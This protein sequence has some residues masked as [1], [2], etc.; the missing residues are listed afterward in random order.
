MGRK[1]LRNPGNNL[2]RCQMFDVVQW[3]TWGWYVERIRSVQ[4][5][6]EEA[7]YGT[8]FEGL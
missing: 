6:A 5:S 3:S 8:F 7:D 2:C 1:G 4:R